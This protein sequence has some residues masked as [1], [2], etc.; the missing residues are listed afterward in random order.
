MD[1]WG[2]E[3]QAEATKSQLG[4]GLQAGVLHGLWVE[5][6]GIGLYTC[7]HQRIGGG[8]DESQIILVIIIKIAHV[9]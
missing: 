1:C 7:E 9:Y 3:S 2:L 6:D 5:P 8:W 4:L